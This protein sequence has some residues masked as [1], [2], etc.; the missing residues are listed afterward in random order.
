M[1]ELKAPFWPVNKG[2]EA[3]VANIDKVFLDEKVIDTPM[4]RNIMISK[5]KANFEGFTYAHDEEL[6]NRLRSKKV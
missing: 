6:T 2:G 3:S 5:S 1:K 4:D